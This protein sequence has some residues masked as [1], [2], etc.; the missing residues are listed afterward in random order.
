MAR[1][2]R[3]EKR[4]PSTKKR[5]LGYAT[6]AT[7][8][9]ATA[10]FLN[11]HGSRDIQA[12]MRTRKNI[13]SDLL[14]QKKS[15]ANILK[16]LDER[17]GYKGSVYKETRNT[18]SSLNHR[19]S[20]KV[21]ILNH[22]N[23]SAS[24]IIRRSNE[25]KKE[26]AVFFSKYKKKKQ[27]Q[28]YKK[29]LKDNN[30]LDPIGD[31][32]VGHELD[33]KSLRSIVRDAFNRHEQA[34][35]IY[36]VDGVVKHDKDFLKKHFERL[37]ENISIN[38]QK[39][40]ED[41]YDSASAYKQD[42]K[43]GTPLYNQ[44]EAA[45]KKVYEAMLDPEN[46]SSFL[47]SRNNNKFKRFDNMVNN[48]TGL[49]ID[50]ER[51]LHGSKKATIKEVVDELKKGTDSQIDPETFKVAME[52]SKGGF[53][54]VLDIGDALQQLMKNEKFSKMAEETE[55]GNGIRVSV[56]KDG[57]K[58][59]YSTQEIDLAKRKAV[60]EFADS[61]L[62]N[63]FKVRDIVQTSRA[64]Y[65][66]GIKA[67]T[68]STLTSY[69]SGNESKRLDNA[70][71]SIAGKLHLLS[72]SGDLERVEGVDV[73]LIS[74]S[75]GS[76]SRMIKDM[77]GSD[78]LPANAS[79][80]KF[81]K[82]LDMEQSGAPNIF[83]R[84]KAG[85]KKHNDPRWDR[86]KLTNVVKDLD[87]HKELNY[88]TDD[89][90]FEIA[91]RFKTAEKA[92][93]NFTAMHN[94]S[95]ETLGSLLET[96]IANKEHNM[97]RIVQGLEPD[98]IQLTESSERLL[99][100]L[101]K[102]DVGEEAIFDQ[103]VFKNA[104]V[105]NRSYEA[106]IRALNYSGEEASDTVG[107]TLHNKQLGD[108]VA[109]HLRDS[110]KTSGVLNINSKSNKIPL[111]GMDISRTSVLDIDDVTRREMIKEV[112]L[113]ESSENSE[114]MYTFTKDLQN[115]SETQRQ[116]LYSLNSWGQMQRA[117][118]NNTQNEGA[119]G[120]ALDIIE[121]VKDV[122]A[123]KVLST[124]I[125]GN[126]A[127]IMDEDYSLAS[128]PFY[129]NMSES[130]SRDYND[131]MAIKK[132]KLSDMLSNMNADTFFDD[133][134]EVG[135]E[136]IAGRKDPTNISLLTT[137]PYGMV[138]RLNYAVEE[139]GLGLSMDSSGSTLDLVKNIGLKRIL[140]VMA[141][142]NLYDYLDYESDN[143]TGTSITAAGA[144]GLARM[145]IGA[146][147]ALD[148]FTFGLGSKAMNWIKESSVAGE[149][150]TGDRSFQNADER[151]DWYENG[152]S[153]VRSSRFW[154]FGSSSEF[155]GNGIAYWQPNYLR[156]AESNWKE[157]G[158][159]G[160]AD[161]KWKHSLIPTLRHPLS[162][163][164]YLLDPY[165][166]EKKHI[167]DRPYPYTG[168][169]FSEG[170]PW[171]AILNP[172]IG[173]LIKP[174]KMLPEIRERLGNGIVDTK[175][176]L[177]DMNERTM[178]EG[179]MNEKM[180]VLDGTD[181]RNAIY[182]PY[183]YA[184]PGSTIV[185]FTG[186]GKPRLQ[187][188]G[189]EKEVPYLDE[190]VSD[191]L[192][193]SSQ[194]THATGM[195]TGMVMD[196]NDVARTSN[197]PKLKKAM[198]TIDDLGKQSG[199]DINL[200]KLL[201]GLNNEA[202]KGSGGSY[203]VG[204]N[205]PTQ[206]GVMTYNNPVG[207]MLANRAQY[208]SRKEDY[209][210]LTTSKHEDYLNDITYSAKQMSGIYSFLGDMAFGEQSYSLR[211]AQAGDMYSFTRG[212][213][214]ASVGGF[215]GN[216]MEIARR[217]FPHED[218]SRPSINPL[219]NS[220]PEWL[221]EKFLTGDAYANLPKGEMRLPGKGYE[222]IYEL[223]SDQ[224]GEYGAFDRMKILADVA[225][226]SE[227]YKIWRKIAQR[228]VTD[229]ELQEEMKEIQARAKK[230]S[231][232]HDFYEY[233]Y[234][235]NNISTKQDVVKSVNSD[236]TLT[237]ASGVRLSF[238]GI[239]FKG[240]ASKAER[241]TLMDKINDEADSYMQ[242]IVLN[243]ENIGMG[244]EAVSSLI[245]AGDKITYKSVKDEVY[246]PGQESVKAVVYKDNPM[247]L[248]ADNIN[249]M[250]Y[251]HGL[252]ER[253]EEDR[254]G[255]SYLA[256]SSSGQE[257][258]GGAIELIA[259]API[260]FVHNKLLKVESALESY[261][262]EMVY[263]TGF[264]TWDTPYQSFIQPALNNQ[265]RKSLAQEALSL[266]MFKL[267]KKAMD[268][269]SFGDK[270][271]ASI[272]LA[273]FNPAAT[274]GAGVGWVTKLRF[275]ENAKIGAEIGQAIGTVGW[276]FANAD[277]PFKAAVGFGYGAYQLAEKYDLNEVVQNAI[278]NRGEEINSISRYAENAIMK[279]LK[280]FGKD[281][282]AS[283]FKFDL[284]NGKA[285]A[286]GAVIGLGVSVL[287][288]PDFDL[289]R[290]RG[291]WIPKETK[292]R[293]ELEEYFDRLQY[294]KYM[295]LYNEASRRAEVLEHSNIRKLFAELD[296]NK[297]QVAKLQRK[298][299]KLGNKYIPGTN[300]YSA[301]MQDIQR[302]I[303]ELEM[304]QQT[305]KGGQWTKSAIAYKKMAESTIYGLNEAST[306]DEILRATPDQYKDYVTAF[307][308]ENSEKKRKEILKNASPQLKK[309]LQ[310]AWGQPVDRQKSNGAYFRFKK[311][312]GMGWKG[313][314][315]NINLKHV[316]MKT[317]ENEGMALS[318][319]GFYES[320]KAK[321]AYHEA[322]D[323]DNYDDKGFNFGLAS[324]ANL[325][326]TMSGA[327][328]SLQNVSVETT[329]APGLWIIGDV[330]RNVNEKAH[331]AGRGID[332]ALYK[333]F[334]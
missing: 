91:D 69:E 37:P 81:A 284:G 52:S 41:I 27:D 187:G 136:L 45:A 296:D 271:A 71:Y 246:E 290:L 54:G 145:D 251:T 144:R 72:D 176:I 322:P 334:L 195:G 39:I 260:P 135:K 138:A 264:K 25:I 134:K 42:T 109:K 184:T 33:A 44:A 19:G 180:F 67:D 117:I 5:L 294:V 299:A 171:G 110:D 226:T 87:E 297:K 51:F 111:L 158:V 46:Y 112:L 119:L 100:I 56:G 254:S 313:W 201:F 70:Y 139:L 125:K 88:L 216:F 66:A 272:G 166:L 188:V 94:V 6:A 148:M 165:W 196:N 228:T 326:M 152:Y 209:I 120:E 206:D 280:A 124:N 8:T 252:A 146:R 168:K 221:P 316:E 329:S 18:I 92:F 7:A 129:G 32:K 331:L 99:R 275:G 273:A 10:A 292:E 259:H 82:M 78:R 315:P 222:S 105:G 104:D 167:D 21:K 57:A 270:I 287:K 308:E 204:A 85:L 192:L 150:W 181:I 161:D 48:F 164:D 309:L 76:W 102:G 262:N 304:Q 175:Q 197:N 198:N 291:N 214:D 132:S 227:E 220:M 211:M 218:R 89:D 283:D 96:S 11:K 126:L 24:A 22:D 98:K 208:Y 303:D 279:G 317:I 247:I 121:G 107:G 128:K 160:S 127:K 307:A 17:V 65:I 200:S 178:Q 163:I 318:D 80:N 143:I 29:I 114:I 34:G 113:R 219:V 261:K 162:T 31:V 255:I 295:G 14:G 123:N 312:P 62:G 263:G 257:V 4:D 253:D 189:Y 101:L 239:K 276:A 230:A 151:E 97:D 147:K 153:A 330:T 173:E 28:V 68:I 86:N 217:F 268:G 300:E 191:E 172:T 131:Y 179:N 47:G 59:F 193:S 83:T 15:A 301:E 74:E 38:K 170:T 116:A 274:V 243:P 157:I 13:K 36:K 190:R 53:N 238:A 223:H 333:L 149:Y 205:M 244:G 324:R 155:R 35:G 203:M 235:N 241:K 174:V 55:F 278:R 75:H 265:F 30:L 310:V 266:S 282:D 320:E 16:A 50:S 215:G 182:T 267:Y 137:V 194:F 118:I 58:H 248:S 122:K 231:T 240:D 93:D 325:M 212:F 332:N 233:R 61:V 245:S 60:D 79:T 95:D 12:L 154:S 269:G 108:I 277:N 156:R 103:E 141:A 293:W 286:I 306:M 63:L 288:N 1:K 84:I 20:E 64:P 249:R 169:M 185:N 236:G 210:A 2:R 213:W 311:L 26:K 140:P 159:Y 242:D 234:V 202:R 207:N 258:I 328:L 323:I 40:L 305:L 23:R 314:K 9:I 298:A 142:Y 186:E 302:Q 327:G 43:K 73:R 130:Y 106:L 232:N 77:L 250:L 183:A 90:V 237:L 285:A 225:P 115:I 256:T 133:A 281:V 49:S 321:A 224:F 319:F 177:K 229:P 199:L 3:D 289:N